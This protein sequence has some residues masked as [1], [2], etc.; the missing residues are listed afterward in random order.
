[1]TIHVTIEVVLNIKKKQWDCMKMNVSKCI[2]VEEI[3][4]QVGPYFY[5]EQD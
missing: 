2:V 1:M 3:N 5:A 4:V